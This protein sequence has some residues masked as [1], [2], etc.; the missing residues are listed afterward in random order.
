MLVCMYGGV[1]VCVYTVMRPTECSQRADPG[2]TKPCH[3]AGGLKPGFL[4]RSAFWLPIIKPFFSHYGTHISK[5]YVWVPRYELVCLRPLPTP[6]RNAESREW[7]QPWKSV[8][9]DGMDRTPLTMA[10]QRLPLRNASWLC[11]RPAVD[12]ELLAGDGRRSFL[13]TAHTNLAGA[14]IMQRL[15]HGPCVSSSYPDNHRYVSMSASL[16]F[17]TTIVLLGLTA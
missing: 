1:G 17:G 16:I 3:N 12:F 6:A 5:V 15:T 11:R 7:G 14:S 13:H 8:G 4:S 9:D 2:S 10:S